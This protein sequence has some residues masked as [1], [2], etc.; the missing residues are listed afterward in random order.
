MA[1]VT[2]P[3]LLRQLDDARKSGEAVQLVVQLHRPKDAPP[4]PADVEAQVRRAI[5]RATAATGEQP[6]DVHVMGRV[7]AAYVQGSE[8]F[9]RELVAQ[10]EVASAVANTTPDVAD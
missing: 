1:R 10:P 8:S 2:D 6:V 7:A 4:V 5:S 9:L 3:E